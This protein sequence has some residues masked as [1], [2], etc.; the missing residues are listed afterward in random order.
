MCVCVRV[1][2]RAF[3]CWIC[4][5]EKKILL[6]HSS[7]SCVK[8]VQVANRVNRPG[9][10]VWPPRTALHDPPFYRW[11]SKSAP[12]WTDLYV[13]PHLNV[14][15]CSAAVFSDNWQL[16]GAASRP[17]FTSPPL[18][19]SIPAEGFFFNVSHSFFFC[20]FFVML[21]NPKFQRYLG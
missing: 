1:G 3:R 15:R 6:Q 18:K 17:C 20:L 5:A 9:N 16:V 13:L 19:L 11:Q 21:H 7:A 12:R 10:C 4:W 14:T 8:Y 2:W